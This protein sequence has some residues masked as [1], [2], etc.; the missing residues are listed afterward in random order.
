MPY[1]SSKPSWLP[2]RCISKMGGGGC[3]GN[4]L[5]TANIVRGNRMSRC[6]QTC[7]E[8]QAKLQP[9]NEAAF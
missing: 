2:W 9:H 5:A 4:S 8:P 3:E 6:I 1:A 7:T